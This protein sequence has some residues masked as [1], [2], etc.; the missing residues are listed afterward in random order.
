MKI[1]IYAG[2]PKTGN[3]FR[4][5]EILL[6]N[7]NINVISIYKSKELRKAIFSI[8]NNS[9]IEFKKKYK[10]YKKILIQS[11]DNK[12]VNILF[13][14]S[15]VLNSIKFKKN[16]HTMLVFKRFFKLLN[17]KNNQ[18]KA[19]LYIRNHVDMLHSLVNQFENRWKKSYNFNVKNILNNIN[20][21]KYSKIFDNLHYISNYKEII[22]LNKKKNT[23]LV[24]YEDFKKNNL[25]HIKDEY[26]FLGLNVKMNNNFFKTKFNNDIL[27]NSTKDLEKKR[28]LRNKL[29]FKNLFNILKITRYFEYFFYIKDHFDKKKYFEKKYFEKNSKIIKEKYR[30][31][32]LSIKNK[33]IIKKFKDYNY[34]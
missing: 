14:E 15:I 19:I 4:L 1:F 5:R 24:L 8:I 32:L 10:I 11:L 13:E 29:K 34:L 9:D 6:K 30:K 25:K 7:E 3:S 26:K 28:S 31:D 22:R 20:N 16:N 2:Y 33:K 23:R 12:K 17:N 18:I 21:K 27:I